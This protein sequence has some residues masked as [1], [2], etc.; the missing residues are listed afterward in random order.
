MKSGFDGLITKPGTADGRL[1]ELEDMTVETSE[2]ESRDLKNKEQKNTERN[3]NGVIQ[4]MLD[5]YQ[6]VHTCIMGLPER[7]GRE[8][9]IKDLFEV[10]MTENFLT[11]M[12]RY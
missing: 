11:L 3:Q 4:E 7:Q 2:L 9:G 6:N 12:F 5:N 8:A 1:S 10:V